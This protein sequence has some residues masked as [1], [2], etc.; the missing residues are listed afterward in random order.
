M[1]GIA[2]SERIEEEY[3]IIAAGAGWAIRAE[4]GRIRLEG[5]DAVSFLHALVT[6]DIESL[7]AG[8]GAYAA[9]LTPQGRMLADMRVYRRPDGLLLEVSLPQVEDLTTR[10]D[11]AVFA[12]DVRVTNVSDAWTQITVIGPDAAGVV[13]RAFGLEAGVAAQLPLWSQLT[14]SDG[15]VVRTEDARA[16]SFDVFAPAFARQTMSQRLTDA[17]AGEV[18]VELLEA[19]RVDA[20]LPAFGLDMDATTIPLEAGLLERAIS[21][22]KGCYVGQEIIVRILHR[23]AGRVAKRLVR[24]VLDADAGLPSAGE[25]LVQ[26]GRETGVVTSAA[27]SP[28]EHRVVAL[29]Y[30]RRDHSA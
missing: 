26:D 18:S 22:N 11:Q 10:L 17:G 9:Y 8:G 4:R 2:N 14:T 19:L 24:Q 23:G 16:L 13:T 6:N 25:P 21:T 12:E 1:T 28:I 29:G 20:G 5:A 3:R 15:F 7:P 27:W 30:V